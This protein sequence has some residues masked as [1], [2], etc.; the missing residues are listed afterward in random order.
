MLGVVYKGQGRG[1]PA[2][3]SRRTVRYSA[4]YGRTVGQMDR[5]SGSGF[6]AENEE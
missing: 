3:R 1:F 4:V 5:G 2:C 6:T